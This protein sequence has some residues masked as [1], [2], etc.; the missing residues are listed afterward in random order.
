M[1]I[2]STCT[3]GDIPLAP[4]SAVC[5]GILLGK[6]RNMSHGTELYRAAPGFGVN[7]T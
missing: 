6:G 2:T 1:V 4:D 3:M 5:C 7:S